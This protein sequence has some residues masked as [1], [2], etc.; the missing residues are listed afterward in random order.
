[1]LWSENMLQFLDWTTNKNVPSYLRLHWKTIAPLSI[2]TGR[3]GIG[4]SV[5]LHML[6]YT[7]RRASI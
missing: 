1:M 6:A 7:M 5:L 2:I 4:K 3:N